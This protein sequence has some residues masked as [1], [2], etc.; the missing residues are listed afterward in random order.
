MVYS[1]LPNGKKVVTAHT[2]IY[3][4]NHRMIDL[5]STVGMVREKPLGWRETIHESI[6][7]SRTPKTERLG[8]VFFIP[9]SWM[10]N[11]LHNSSIARPFLQ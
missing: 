11:F 7:H 4:G 3:I 5:A 10:T 2:A 6:Q 8:S 9:L 1:Y